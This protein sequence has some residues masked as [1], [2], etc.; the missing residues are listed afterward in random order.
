MIYILTY[1]IVLLL[2]FSCVN[3]EFVLGTIGRN[4]ACNIKKE[5][6]PASNVFVVMAFII[7]VTLASC[8]SVTVG[9]DTE[10]YISVF[11]SFVNGSSF[12]TVKQY[13]NTVEPLYLRF[14]QLLASICSSH[15]FYLLINSVVIYGGVL[16]YI[17]KNSCNV[18][19]SIMIF[20]ALYYTST[21]NIMRQY[22]AIGIFLIS[23]NK[24]DERKYF[25]FSVLC[26]IAALFHSSILLM[27][28]IIVLRIIHNPEKIFWWV[29][30]GAFLLTIVLSNFTLV[31]KILTLFN[32]GRYVNSYHMRAAD[33]RGIMAYIYLVIVAIGIFMALRLKEEVDDLFYCNL[34]ISSIG[35]AFTVLASK[36]EMFVRAG[37]GYLLFVV[38]L[39]PEI[40]EKLFSNGR[41]YKIAQMCTYGFLVIA[42]IVSSRSYTYTFGL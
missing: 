15:F 7:L 11:N 31:N 24:F 13:A 23:L 38:L 2:G 10:S 1:F 26:C 39:L 19:M 22:V 33:S 25:E 32:Y 29:E 30:I 35:V 4:A 8:R 9:T 42:T 21:F 41:S 40:L 12:Q 36:N 20:I 27:L 6:I 14:T 17:R 5:G 28:P 18:V 34:M 3:K 16:S 37:A